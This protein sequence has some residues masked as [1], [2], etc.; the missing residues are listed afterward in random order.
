MRPPILSLMGVEKTYNGHHGVRS[1]ELEVQ[2]G[3]FLTLLGPSG[4]GKTTTLNLIAGLLE[5]ERG[6]VLLRGR[7]IT[8]LPPAKRDMGV[9]FQ[10]YA[11]FPHKTVGA[12]VG[13][14][15][16]MRGVSQPEIQRR[17]REMLE[18][19]GLPGVER[20][21]PRQL[22][23]GQ[24]QRVALARAL[25]IQPTVLLLDEPLSNLDAVLRK[26]MREELR[27]I[28][29]ELGITSIFVT[30]DQE[31]AFEVS[32]RVVLMKDGAIEQQG[33]P[34][35][36]YERPHSRFAAEFIGESNFITGPVL[37]REGEL[38]R[39]DAG[40][41]W[42]LPARAGRPCQIGEQATVVIRPEQI[43]LQEW[44][45]E[46][47]REGTATGKIS[48]RAFSGS[49]LRF[50]LELPGEARL[51]V[52]KQNLPEYDRFRAGMPVSFTVLNCRVIHD[53]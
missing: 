35:E 13:F 26:R 29:R 34:E 5:P 8:D 28:Q 33:T 44:L 15:L 17:S 52:I 20:R 37:S 18:L 27:S 32:D 21:Y 19:V 6:T 12:N 41:G 51:R 40:N 42:V 24:R 38:V 39:V 16:K 47:S 49:A 25:V 22:S 10:N 9:V 11:L 45:G 4:C 43:E 46:T 14:G 1:M 31:E 30:H 50:T 3:E 48:E 23:G 36:L 7:D 2:E 53:V